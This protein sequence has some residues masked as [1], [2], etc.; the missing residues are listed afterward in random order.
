MRRAGWDPVVHP[1]VPLRHTGDAKFALKSFSPASNGGPWPECPPQPK[2][3]RPV[4]V[5]QRVRGAQGSA[6][7][8]VP[9]RVELAVRRAR[10]VP[11]RQ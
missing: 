2:L 11:A 4:T 10:Q 5:L 8:R 9:R 7:G 1:G 6:A 3:I